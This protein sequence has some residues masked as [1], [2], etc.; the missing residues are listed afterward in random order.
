MSL[1]GVFFCHYY[2]YYYYYYIV[3][4]P[5]FMS[6]VTVFYISEDLRYVEYN[7]LVLILLCLLMLGRWKISNLN[8]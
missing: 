6:I 1:Y 2:Y 4:S 5:T 3:V 8:L 7:T